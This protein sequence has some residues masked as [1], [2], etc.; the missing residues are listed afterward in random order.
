MRDKEYL[1]LVLDI[2][3]T[4]LYFIQKK[5]RTHSWDTL[6][7]T[8]KAKYDF[9]EDKHGNILIRRPYLKEFFAFLFPHCSVNL[10]T[11]SDQ[12]YADGIA[13]MI[14]TRY[15]PGKGYKF[16]S[17]YCDK[18]DEESAE[19]FGGRKNLKYFYEDPKKKHVW[20][21]NTILIDDLPANSANAQNIANSITIKPF[22]LFG[23]VK[24]RSDPYEDV[25]TDRVLLDI[26]E[27][28]QK[29]I[30]DMAPQ[31]SIFSDRNCKR[32][33]ITHLLKHIQ[34]KQKTGSPKLVTGI[35]LG[36]SHLFAKSKT[37]TKS[38]SGSPK[39]RK[40]RRSRRQK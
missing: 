22:A 3:E 28:L 16:D 7:A 20:P 37:R 32:L 35:G 31:E 10:W 40:N 38:K 2:D 30:A 27:L 23:E 13:N 8:E 14:L 33:G 39:T 6:P 18:T 5:Y 25:S 34:L 12:E 29:I 11:L 9:S 19:Y 15:F 17:I 26:V 24:D 36:N 1:N 21:G 4:L